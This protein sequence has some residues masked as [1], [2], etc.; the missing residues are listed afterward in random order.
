MV[1]LSKYPCFCANYDALTMMTSQKGEEFVH[2]KSKSC[3]YFTPTSKFH[4]YA[5][6]FVDQVHQKYKETKGAKCMHREPAS[7]WLSSSEK[8]PGRMFCSC[9]RGNQDSCGYF[10]WS[11]VY[12]SKVTRENQDPITTAEKATWTGDEPMSP[13]PPPQQ[14]TCEPKSSK[15]KRGESDVRAGIPKLKFKKKDP[16]Q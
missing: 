10:Q 15:K 12:P 13:P 1:S 6:A 8:N 3:G 4:L 14:K 2:C 11:N 7:L 5:E 9:G 16:A